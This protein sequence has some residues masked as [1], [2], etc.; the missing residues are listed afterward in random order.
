MRITELPAELYQL[1]ETLER[2]SHTIA[3]A[4]V[5]SDKQARLIRHLHQP[6]LMNARKL[7]E[8]AATAVLRHV[9]REKNLVRHQLIAVVEEAIVNSI[10]LDVYRR[11]GDEW[12]REEREKAAEEKR[13]NPGIA[14]REASACVRRQ[15]DR[16]CCRPSVNVSPTLRG[17]GAN[18]GARN[19]DARIR[20]ARHL[21]TDR[22]CQPPRCG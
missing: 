15:G 14:A 13:H 7:A 17:A 3:Q 22:S 12:E 2:A 4:A 1:A 6:A 8:V 9:E 10:T 19:H 18:N 16:G 5:G 21:R 11:A 20:P